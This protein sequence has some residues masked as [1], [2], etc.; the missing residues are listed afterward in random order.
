MDETQAFQVLVV[1]LSVTLA[2][3]LVLAIIATTWLIKV[4]KNVNSITEKADRVAED[5][6][7]A[8]DNFKRNAG[9]VAAVQTLL[10][11]FKR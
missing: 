1:I 10:S 7:A 2:V 4:L 3:F 5:I 11:L 6:E 9:P 8:A